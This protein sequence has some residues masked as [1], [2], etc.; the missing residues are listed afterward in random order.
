MGESQGLGALAGKLVAVG[1][2]LDASTWLLAVHRD[3]AK[4]AKAD[5][6]RHGGAMH[7]WAKGRASKRAVKLNAW[8]RTTSEST[9]VRPR[10]PGL[11]AIRE[12]GAKAHTSPK[13][14]SKAGK[15]KKGG[16]VLTVPG[17]PT[18][19]VA[20]VNHPGA[21]GKQRWTAVRHDVDREAP[22]LVDEAVKRTLRGVFGSG[23]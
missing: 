5:A 8:D 21:A 9:Q 22:K 11:W 20:S 16:K 1:T 18:G 3:I 23:G 14:R 19:F 12:D 13:R 17:S 15:L 6:A 10:Q 4:A 7:V 2:A